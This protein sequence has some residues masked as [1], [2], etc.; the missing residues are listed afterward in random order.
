MYVLYHNPRCS[1]SRE[2][3]KMCEKSSHNVR[4]HRYLESPLS[5]IELT[6]I[7]QR[8]EGNISRIIRTNDPAFKR[9]SAVSIDDM[10]RDDMVLFL[11]ENGHLM[12]RPL[13][14]T[15]SVTKIGRPV[16]DLADYLQ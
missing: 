12:E 2:A 1:K 5:L 15:G 9:L 14:D 6:S 3:V 8:L 11:F 13:L 10:S 7:L 4:I 16:H